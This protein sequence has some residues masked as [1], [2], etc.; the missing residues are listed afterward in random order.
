MGM[1]VGPGALS[2][3]WGLAHEFMHGVQSVSGGQSCNGSN[4]CGWIYESHA[5]W[6]AQQQEE[7]HTGDVHCS[8]M[9]ANMP[10]LHL[11][12]TRDRYCNWQFMEYLKDKHCF[13]AVHAMWTGDATADPFTGIREGMG[14]TVADL[15]DFMGDWAMH[16]VTWDY[17]DPL[18]QSSGGDNLGTLFRGEYGLVTDTRAAGW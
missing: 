8:E 7:Y 4:T 12:S 17:E 16:N 9:R 13:S 1:W 2:D 5:N 6:A 3:H 11:G 15:N 10:H 14:W 18:P